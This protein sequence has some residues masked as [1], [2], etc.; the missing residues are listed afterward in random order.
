MADEISLSG[1][2]PLER[3]ADT[4]PRSRFDWWGEVK[5]LVGLVLAVLGFHSFIAKPFYIPSE[6]ML[7]GLMVGDRLETDI[8]GAHTAGLRTALVLTGISKRGDIGNRKLDFVLEDLAA[9]CGVL[10]GSSLK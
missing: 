4:P 3:R 8:D 9:L 7:P 6:S 5:G 1:E 2:P 10:E